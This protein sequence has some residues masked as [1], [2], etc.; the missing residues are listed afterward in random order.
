MGLKDPSKIFH[1]YLTTAAGSEDMAIDG[2]ATSTNF[3]V[4]AP[5]NDAVVIY[6]MLVEYSDTKNMEPEEYGDTGGSLS[7]GLSFKVMSSDG[8]TEIADLTQL[9]IKTNSDWGRV[10][11]DV[12]VGN[13]NNTTNASAHVRWTFEKSGQPIFLTPG[14]R[15]QVAVKDDMSGLLTHTC[16]V[17]GY[18][19]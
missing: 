19:V 12:N 11:Y 17:Q 3:Y 8:T 16:F 18:K 13:F 5:A 2:S 14:R 7:A 10:A 6:R 4:S 1:R 15:L 9:P